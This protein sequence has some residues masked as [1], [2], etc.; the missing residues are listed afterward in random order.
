MSL[1]TLSNQTKNDISKL[2]ET[3]K[4]ISDQTKWWVLN[5]TIEAIKVAKYEGDFAIITHKVRKQDI[6]KI[7]LEIEAIKTLTSITDNSLSISKKVEKINKHLK[8]NSDKLNKLL[9]SFHV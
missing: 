3:I 6:N 5:T 4:E 9:L 7:S 1:L 8:E 2:L